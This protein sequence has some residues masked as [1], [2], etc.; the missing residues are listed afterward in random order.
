MSR[1]Y[2][3]T[4]IY[5]VG[6]DKPT[7]KETILIEANDPTK[8]LKGAVQKFSIPQF[9]EFE[10]EELKKTKADKGGAFL[11]DTVPDQILIK[12]ATTLKV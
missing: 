6:T 1:V 3:A 12:K 8:A 4:A 9:K 2:E 7:K 11:K 10:G 5:N